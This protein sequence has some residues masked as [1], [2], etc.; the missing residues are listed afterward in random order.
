[1]PSKIDNCVAVSMYQ[2]GNAD[3]KAVNT[4]VMGLMHACGLK[5][6]NDIRGNAVLSRFDLKYYAWQV[7]VFSLACGLTYF[8]FTNEVISAQLTFV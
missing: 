7:E 2:D 8:S 3:Q 6:P 1:M 5:T 4:R